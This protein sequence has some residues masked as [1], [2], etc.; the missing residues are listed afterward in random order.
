MSCRDFFESLPTGDAV[1]LRA[2]LIDQSH[3]RA[4]CEVESVSKYSPGLVREDEYIV[5]LILT[6][7]HFQEGKVVPA[8]FSDVD[9]KGLSCQR[10]A[11]LVVTAD[12]HAFG[13]LLADAQNESRPDGARAES[14]KYV[15]A[16]SAKVAD[17]R[18]LIYE[19]RSRVFGIYDTALPDNT[20]HIDVFQCGSGPAEK[21]RLRKKMRDIFFLGGLHQVK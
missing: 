16:L 1:N 15:G 9:D 8:A 5:R 10:Q 3:P 6:P 20:A 19:N 4:C 2:G 21:K 13:P 17:I 11:D 14:R 18:S 12:T 7:H